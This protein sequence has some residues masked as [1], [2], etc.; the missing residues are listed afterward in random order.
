M[1]LFDRSST[2]A[3]KAQSQ[4]K[5]PGFRLHFKSGLTD[6][7]ETF[8][9]HGASFEQGWVEYLFHVESVWNSVALARFHLKFHIQ[10][11]QSFKVKLG[12]KIEWRKGGQLNRTN[13]NGIAI[14]HNPN[15]LLSVTIWFCSWIL[16]P[17]ATHSQIWAK[18]SQYLGEKCSW[19]CRVQRKQWTIC[20]K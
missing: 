8:G 16:L 3:T 5:S 15:E 11:N 17:L 18:L 10:T 13:G 4:Q 20:W 9:K 14:C 19:P 2:Y 6:I 1:S 12:D 7:H